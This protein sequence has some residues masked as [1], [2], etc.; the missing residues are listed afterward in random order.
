MT[1]KRRARLVTP[2]GGN[3]FAKVYR[4]EEK[5]SDVNLGAHLVWDACHRLL[6]VAVV[7]SN[8]SDLQTPLNMAATAGIQVVTVNPHLHNAQPQTLFGTDTRRLTKGRLARNLLPDPV[9]E[10]NGRR[11]S[12]PQ[13]W[14]R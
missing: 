6:D 14:K 4:T 10:G 8:D 3:V 2:V 13:Q 5:G 1:H 9:I 7:V 12:R 11:I